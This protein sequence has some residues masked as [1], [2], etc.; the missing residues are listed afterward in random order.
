MFLDRHIFHNTDVLASVIVCETN[1]SW[2]PQ[3]KLK[4]IHHVNFLAA[5]KQL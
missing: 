4:F 5:T 2:R 3:S 1:Y